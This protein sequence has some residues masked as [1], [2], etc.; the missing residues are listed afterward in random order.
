M[1][2]FKKILFFD[3]D[4]Y[5]NTQNGITKSRCT[6]FFKALIVSCDT[7]MIGTNYPDLFITVI[8][9]KLLFPATY[10]RSVE[11]FYHRN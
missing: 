10:R 4:R 5:P 1:S 6:T 7:Y 11:Y 8:N 2:Q 9:N 3:L